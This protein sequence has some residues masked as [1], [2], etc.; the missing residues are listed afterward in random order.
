MAVAFLDLRAAYRELHLELD[1]ACRRVMESGWYILGEEVEA[2]EREWAAYCGVR[3]C[4]GVGNGFDA[5][6]LTLKAYGIGPGDEVIVPA[7]TFIA[8]WLA[9]SAVGAT[10]I[11][12]EPDP[13]TYNLDPVCLA[14][15]VTSRTRA[16][17]PVHLYGQPAEMAPI[18]AMA[19]QHGLK[20]VEDA[21]QAHGAQYQGCRVGGLGDAA[22]WSF[23]PGKN[24][25][26]LGDAGA[27]TTND[28]QLA[29]RLRLLRNYGSQAKY[30][31]AM[32]GMNSRLDPLQAACLRV[33]LRHLDEWNARRRALAQ[34]Y[35]VALADIPNLTLPFVADGVA[36]V[37]HLFAVRHPQRDRLQQHL[38]QAGI[39][40]LIHYPVPPHLSGAYAERTW[41]AVHFPITEGLAESVL[42]LP[43]GPHLEHHA[44]AD[45]IAAL[46]SL[47]GSSTA[48]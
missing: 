16:I 24:L 29:S 22:G 28:D 23:Y 46:R 39:E 37:W 20:V 41:R 32:K 30:Y 26:A 35:M 42:S 19:R 9:V 10:P 25:G 40:T 5:L 13:H 21:A 38:R 17:I 33:K 34:T 14:N 4:I 47:A 18:V 7:H 27:V 15:A 43:I 6:H 1:A 11:P 8:T 45:V 31:N 3:H 48:A 36:P 2:F 44:A 12:V